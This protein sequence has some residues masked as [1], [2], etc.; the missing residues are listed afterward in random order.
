MVILTI[1][2]LYRPEAA[3]LWGQQKRLGHFLSE[4]KNELEFSL[5]LS[6]GLEAGLAFTSKFIGLPVANNSLWQNIHICPSSWNSE[7]DANVLCR[8]LGHFGGGLP[9]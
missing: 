7:A 3:T 6:S 2:T 4:A 8:S 5:A 9:R 1:F